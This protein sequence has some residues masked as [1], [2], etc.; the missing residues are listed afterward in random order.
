MERYL[1]ESLG[2]VRA[3]PKSKVFFEPW[4]CLSCLLSMVLNVFGGQ[5]DES[6]I[7]EMALSQYSVKSTAISGEKQA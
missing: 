6:F 2:L 4:T 3:K 5:K 1:V 7:A